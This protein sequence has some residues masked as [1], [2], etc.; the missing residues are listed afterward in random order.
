MS[1]T[2]FR[3]SL[4]AKDYQKIR[5]FLPD[6]VDENQILNILGLPPEPEIELSPVQPGEDVLPENKKKGTFSSILHGLIEEA[7]N[8]RDYQKESERIKDY[9][10]DWRDMHATGPQDP[11]S[12]YSKHRPGKRSKSGPVGFAAEEIEAE[13]EVLVQD[14]IEE[15]NAVEFVHGRA[16]RLQARYDDPNSRALDNKKIKISISTLEAEELEE[17]SAMGPAG[18]ASVEGHMANPWIKL[19]KKKGKSKKDE[20]LVNEILDYL[21]KDMGEQ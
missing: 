1:A 19:R 10:D 20:Q 2:D 17:I 13:G 11:G 14:E 21:L 3:K 7:I 4:A 15:T 16:G 9:L 6:K 5:E 18:G 12:A 8:E